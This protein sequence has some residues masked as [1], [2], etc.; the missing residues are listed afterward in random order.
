[1]A[2]FGNNGK[3]AKKGFN[4]LPLVIA[5]V[6]VVAVG[7]TVLIT[8]MN[9]NDDEQ[10]I[11][12]T[13][14]VEHETE[15]IKKGEKIT[16]ND[17]SLGMIE[18][19]AVAGFAKNVYENDNF[20]IDDKGMMT[21]YI[22]NEVASC[23][24]VDLSE[25]QGDVDFNKVKAQGFDFVM[26]RLGGRYYGEEGDFYMDSKFYDYFEG[27][28]DAGLRVGGYFFSQAKN[29]EEAVEEANYF[30]KQTKGLEF[31]YPVAFDWETIE[32][33]SARTDNVSSEDLTAAAIAFCDT[34]KE[35]GNTAIIYSNTYLMYYK[36][37]LEELKDIDF[38]VADY[39]EHP[40]MY[41]NFTMW[42]YDIEGQVDGIE[43]NVDM[44]ICMKNY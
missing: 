36:Y 37:N 12:P 1:M 14:F 31:D 39:E 43:G 44:N 18:I 33:D 38:W 8:T 13:E 40:S 24:G 41:Y 19:D 22:D 29:A 3:H 5:L 6:L 16:I 4:I 34:I 23:M 2:I 42:Q 17:P 15:K 21:Y 11:R 25:Y 9:N 30:L 28:K 7:A 27:A 32:G 35:S 26:L 20:I 10:Q